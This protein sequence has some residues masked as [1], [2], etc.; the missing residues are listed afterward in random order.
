MKTFMK[1][2]TEHMTLMRRLKIQAQIGVIHSHESYLKALDDIL[3]S[4]ICE[5]LLEEEIEISLQKPGQIYTILTLHDKIQ[6]YFEIISNLY[7][8][9]QTVFVQ[10]NKY[11]GEFI[12]F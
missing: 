9:H 11:P 3:E 5:F 10:T 2:F 7:Y 4:S 12:Y 1:N 8:I 6:P